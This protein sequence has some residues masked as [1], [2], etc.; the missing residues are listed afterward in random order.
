MSTPLEQA[1]LE[2]EQLLADFVDAKQTQVL[3]ATYS[4][5][6]QQGFPY[7]WQQEFHN[8]SA[9]YP[10]RGLVAANQVGKTRTGGADAAMHLTGWY[11]DWYTG[12]RFNRPVRAVVAGI[13]NQVLRDVQQLSLFGGMV[14]GKP[15]GNG[16]IPLQ[17]IR[18]FSVRQCGITDV[19]DTARIHHVSGGFSEVLMKSYEQGHT[20]FQGIPAVDVIWLDEEPDDHRVFSECLARLVAGGGLLLFTRTPLMGLTK[21]VKYFMTPSE[22]V[23][24]KT[25][26]W[27]DAPHLTDKNKRALLQGFPEHERATRTKGLPMMGTGGVYDVPDSMIEIR[28][29]Q[30]PEYWRRICGIDFGIDHPAAAVWLAHDP[31]ADVVYIYD[32]YK[33]R[34][35]TAAYHAGAIKQRGDWIPV[36]WPHDGM[37]RD[38][39]GGETLADTYRTHG[40]KMLGISA[41]YA[42]DKGGGQPREPATLELLERMRT[43]RLKVFGH[44][45]EW[46]EEKAMLI[47]EDGKIQA[48][49]DDMESATRYAIMMLR[50][51]ISLEETESVKQVRVSEYDPLAQ[52]SV[53]AE[54]R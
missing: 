34:G 16:W 17:D 50:C 44:L 40:V 6:A 24:C 41:R 4:H 30:I 13:T 9:I 15:E 26:T 51:A 35:Q 22:F 8:N 37:V 42:D 52:F 49:N 23:Y 29:F 46:F 18:S 33:A 10:H 28:P 45:H 5:S 1:Q 31:D 21:I 53:A 47:R 7:P 36:A 11:P 43:G 48:E 54:R 32:A 3:K 2:L 38:K 12:F 27:D 20:K 19:M 39:A 14:D 25:A